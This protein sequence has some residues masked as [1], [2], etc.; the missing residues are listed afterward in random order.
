MID[1]GIVGAGRL[2]E[3]IASLL[4]RG[5]ARVRLWA[6]KPEAAESLAS[7]VAGTVAHRDPAEVL[8]PASLVILAVPAGALSEA[9]DVLGP[10]ARGDQV[11]L[12]A[13]RGV[14]PGFVLPHQSI[15]AKTCVRK[16]AA[17]GGPLHA[18]ELHLGRP[19]A[20]VVASRYSEAS[21]LV[22]KLV[23]GSIVRV[24]P[25]RDLVGVEIAGAFSNVGAIAQGISEGLELG[26]TSRGVLALRGLA[27]AQRI[28][29][30]FGADPATF[31]GLAGVGDLVPRRTSSADRHLMLGRRLAKG[32]ALAEALEGVD[33]TSVEGIGTA[34]EAR[35]LT[36]SRGARAPLVSAV[37][38]VLGGKDPRGVM[39]DLLSQD[40]EGL[41]F[42]R[43]EC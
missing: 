42:S 3:V 12:H 16:I 21:E 4:A 9:S 43:S 6:R 23:K 26:E 7:R 39:D 33:P 13:C 29:A 24:H 40:L 22:A 32:M 30:L 25:S 19:L 34:L 2:A 38:A 17:L 27:E 28:G 15:R 1:V 5:P 8:G 35:A 36:E 41:A 10:F 11:V 20:A 18:R 14:S 31:G 37:A